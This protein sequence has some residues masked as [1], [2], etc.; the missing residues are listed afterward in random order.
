MAEIKRCMLIILDGCGERTGDRG[1]AISAAKTPVLDSIRKDHPKTVLSCSGKAVGLPD[2]FMGNSE[3]GHLNIGAGRVVHQ[4]L[5]RIDTAVEDG[6][7]YENE[8]I[9]GLID[10]IR[11]NEQGALHFIGLVSDGGVHSHIR[12]LFALLEAAKSKGVS[13]AYVHVI[14]DGR[15]TSPTGGVDYIKEVQRKIDELKFGE[16]ADVCGRYFAMDRDGRWDRT[17]KAYRLY[18]E[19]IGKTAP[20]P[21]SAVKESY[22]I[23]QT[24][25]FIRPIAVVDD[26]G[27]PKGVVRSGDGIFFFNFR[28]DRARQLTRAFTESNFGQFPRNHPPRLAGFVTMTV[29]DETFDLPAAFGPVHL[30]RILGEIVAEAGGR[31]LRIAETEKYAH[32]TYFFNGGEETAFSGEDRKLIPSPREVATYDEKPEM[33]AY[34]VTEAVISRLREGKYDL[35][36]LNFANMDMVGHTGVFEAAVKACETVDECLGK[37]LAEARMAGYSALVT[38]DHG[39]A[40]EMQTPNGAVYT[41]HTKNP[42]PFILVDDDRGGASLR[43]GGVLG[44]IAPTILHLM[45]IEKPAEMSGKTLII[46]SP[47]PSA[48]RTADPPA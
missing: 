46:D 12:H 10:Q 26:T 9:A 28:A 31:Q 7:F 25:E 45:E 43:E 37:I 2:G 4:D 48:R 27:R 40:E 38:A 1:N 32:V 29:Y 17:E 6:T 42:V 14:T 13:Q 39:N 22:E 47:L 33:S 3:V 18:T 30:D 35:I 15:D 8:A 36:V 23:N 21:V 24:D 44:D 11:K 19:G 34:E 20:D 5:L 41:A 16:I